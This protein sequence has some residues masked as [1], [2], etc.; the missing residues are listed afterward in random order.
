[1]VNI[2]VLNFYQEK[3]NKEVL[4]DLQ[5]SKKKGG[6]VLDSLDIQWVIIYQTDQQNV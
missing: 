1:V 5:V 3:S 4:E 2:V 6:A